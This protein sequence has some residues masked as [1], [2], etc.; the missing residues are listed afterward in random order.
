[1]RTPLEI[2]DYLVKEAQLYAPSR[3]ALDAVCHVLQDYSRL[4]AE[5]RKMRARLADID[6]ESADLDHLISNLQQ[7]ARSILD[8]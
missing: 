4:V 1:M 8:L 6:L 7:I 2:P 3:D 5:S